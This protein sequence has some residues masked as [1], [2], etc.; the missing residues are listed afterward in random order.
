MLPVCPSSHKE[1]HSTAHATP[2]R[3][4]YQNL[5]PSDTVCSFISI[6]FEDAATNA[7]GFDTGGG[8]SG[9]ARAGNVFDAFSVSKSNA[10]STKKKNWRPARL[11]HSLSARYMCGRACRSRQPV[12]LEPAPHLQCRHGALSPSRHV[13]APGNVSR[14][15]QCRPPPQISACASRAKPES[16][17]MGVFAPKVC[18][19][20]GAFP[21]THLLPG[22]DAGEGHPLRTHHAQKLD[23]VD[24]RRGVHLPGRLLY[25]STTVNSTRRVEGVRWARGSSSLPATTFC[26]L[27]TQNSNPC[28]H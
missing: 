3:R 21:I 12:Y 17:R 9:K 7:R 25:P 20:R 22:C 28:I 4:E 15:A 10:P 14:N 24:H 11:L 27:Q 1:A 8:S 26:A 19:W 16:P 5:A 13:A 18:A 2:C 23:R 6:A